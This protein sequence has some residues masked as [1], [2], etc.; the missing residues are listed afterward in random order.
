[1]ILT[2][3]L[4]V[5]E[6][7]STEFRRRWYGDEDAM[8]EGAT[9]TSCLPLQ[10]VLKMTGITHIDFVSLDVEGAELKVLETL[11]FSAVHINVIVI[12]QDGSRPDK[13]QA[14]RKLLAAKGFEMDSS[15]KGMR[16]GGRN[17]WFVNKYFKPSAA[18]A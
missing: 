12:E 10:S 16:A 5:Q 1:M 4:D 9:V 17:D 13:D 7:M 14:V 2:A 8:P 3:W 11:D 6:F 15:V 18:P